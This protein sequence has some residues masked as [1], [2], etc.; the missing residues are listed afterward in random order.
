MSDAADVPTM[1]IRTFG[2]NML[3]YQPGQQISKEEFAAVK[4]AYDYY[5]KKAMDKKMEQAAKMPQLVSTNAPDGTAL[6]L[7]VQ[8]DG[9]AQIIRPTLVNSKQGLMS[10]RN[11]TNAVPVLDPAT[12]KPIMGYAAEEGYGE[13]APVAFGQM[14]PSATNAPTPAAAP[15]PT[16][17]PEGA[18]I[19]SKADGQIY[20]IVNG[21]P[22]LAQP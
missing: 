9:Q 10:M 21:T 8:P 14:G 3:G 12:G 17:Y 4:Q 2:I 15:A 7:L 5:I 1:D 19:R 6:N 22:V 13:P 16:P 11:P 20:T 18:K